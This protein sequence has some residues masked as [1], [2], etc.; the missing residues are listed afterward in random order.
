VATDLNLH[1][2][3]WT[4]H[5]YLIG[6]DNG[7]LFTSP[8]GV[9]W[10]RVR[11]PAFHSIR[12]FAIGGGTTVAAGAGT[13]MRLAR[14]GRWTLEEI[15]LGRFQTSVAYG[16]GRF[17]IVGHNGEVLVSTDGGRT[18]TAATMPAEINLDRIVYADGRFIAAGEGL[19][20]TSRDGLTWSSR[21]LPTSRSIRS[22]AVVGS[23]L[24]AVG[25]LD[26]ILRSVDGGRRWRAAA[27]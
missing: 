24:I 16:G 9:R 1:V 2:V 25:D 26:T 15:G 18:W 19:E 6:S 21:R 11:S 7:L 22:I 20:V 23:R 8:N 17:V 14:N 12:D 5:A 10:R 3:A 4:G 13:V 27:A